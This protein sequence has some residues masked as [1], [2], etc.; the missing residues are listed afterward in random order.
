MSQIRGK[1]ASGL[2][3]LSRSGSSPAQW[4][5]AAAHGIR[6]Y[7]AAAVSGAPLPLEGYRVLDMTRVLAGPYCTQILGD[8]GA[9]VIK[10]EHPTR[11]DDTRAWGPPYAEY[12]PESGRQ[13]PG[14]SAYFLGA[15]RNKKS[16][17][18]SFQHQGGVDILHKLAAKC[19]ILVENYLPGTLKKYSMDYES[20]RKINPGLIYASITG[21]GQTG[22]YSNRAGYDVMVEAE[23]GLMHITGSRDGPPVKVG[24]AV[25]DLTTG[26]YTSNS[27]MAA[28]LSRART[29]KGQHIDVALSDCQTATLANIASSSLISGK[30]DSGRWGTAH[31][32]IVPYR[33]FKT[34]DGD[35]LI[36]GGND[37]LFGVLCD[38]IGKPHWKD[39]AKFKT[40][41]DR[42]A[43]RNELEAEIEAITQQ[44][45]TQ[46]WL[47]VFEGSGMPYAAINDVQGTLNHSH[48]KARDMVIE[49]DHEYCGPIK[50]VNTPVKWSETQP[51]V[52][53]PP[54]VLGQHTDE[55]LSEHLGLSEA[56][57]AAL[58]DQG[59]VR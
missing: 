18:L 55:I 14:E 35:I 25:T 45:T 2:A 26:L 24:V 7:S 23:F 27:I 41:A 15:N 17:G 58:K 3:R 28:L 10:I 40:N 19:D 13:G 11:G 8:L 6:R 21:Y 33:A 22:P 1:A 54:P 47:E 38:G 31:P 9:E 43:H 36:G 32:S 51:I 20:L 44:R 16:L 4:L 57:I 34:K 12:K 30:K 29:G 48:T 49:I 46:E 52:R 37:R 50:M 5:N 53:T 56:D 42:V 39:D 59:V